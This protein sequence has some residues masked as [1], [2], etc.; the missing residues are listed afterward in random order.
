[1]DVCSQLTSCS[2]TVTGGFIFMSPD[3]ESITCNTERVTSYTLYLITDILFFLAWVQF[4]NYWDD[5]IEPQL[6]GTGG[7]AVLNRDQV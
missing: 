4:S 1:M 6:V 3:Y 2:E 5:L 7:G